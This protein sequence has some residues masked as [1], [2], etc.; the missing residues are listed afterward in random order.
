[1]T[2]KKLLAEPRIFEFFAENIKQ[3]GSKLSYKDF[4]DSQFLK[5][6]L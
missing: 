3:G 2:I 6:T 4:H 5:L 1:M